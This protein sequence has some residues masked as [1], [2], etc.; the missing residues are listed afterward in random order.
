MGRRDKT[1]RR[2]RREMWGSDSGSEGLVIR[3]QEGG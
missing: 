3:R 2:K 1:G